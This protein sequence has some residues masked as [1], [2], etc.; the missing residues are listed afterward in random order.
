MIGQTVRISVVDGV[1]YVDE[2]P[3]GVT[4]EVSDYDVFHVGDPLPIV[5]GKQQNPCSTYSVTAEDIRLRKQA[6]AQV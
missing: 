4:V 1:A 6:A 2:V 5:G 3:P